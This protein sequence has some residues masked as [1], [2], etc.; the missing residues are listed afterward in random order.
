M[1]RIVCCLLLLLLVGGAQATSYYHNV[2]MLENLPLD[3]DRNDPEAKAAYF[4][5]YVAGVADST[6][7]SAWC[8]PGDVKAEQT[9]DMVSKYMKD[10]PPTANQGAVAVVT[11][12]LA[13]NFPCRS[14]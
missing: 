5:G 2:D 3:Y 7:D 9:Y 10:H 4:R 1:K 11:T 8:P 14:K 6:R 13:T 12:A